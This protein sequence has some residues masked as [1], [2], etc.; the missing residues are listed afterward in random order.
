MRKRNGKAT[1]MI[2]VWLPAILAL[3]AFLLMLRYGWDKTR[4][5]V[6]AA[7]AVGIFLLAG[8][9]F[10]M[11]AVRTG[12]LTVISFVILYAVLLAL[13]FWKNQKSEE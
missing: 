12:N 11:D 2:K 4:L 10:K 7:G 3:A 6:S 5:S 13:V 9:Y 1:E 8:K